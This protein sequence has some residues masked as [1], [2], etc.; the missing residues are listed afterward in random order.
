[1][2][3]SLSPVNDTINSVSNLVNNNVNDNLRVNTS[4]TDKSPNNNNI[5]QGN[6][7]TNERAIALMQS[8]QVNGSKRKSSRRANTAERRATHN[9]VEQQ[10]R[11]TLNGCLLVCPLSLHPSTLLLSFHR[12]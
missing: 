10:R 7:T 11:E 8:S 4:N 2:V 9:A 3:M 12:T 1:M 6:T 5:D